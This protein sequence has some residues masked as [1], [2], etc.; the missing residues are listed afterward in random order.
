MY[1]LC[2]EIASNAHRGQKR[3]NGKPYFSYHVMPIARHFLS[4]EDMAGACV[5]LLHDTIEDHP[6]LVSVQTLQTAGVH[7]RIIQA[8]YAITKQPGESYENYLNR[9]MRNTLAWKVKIQD[10]LHNIS[11]GA[12]HRRI[13]KYAAGLLVLTEEHGWDSKTPE[14]AFPLPSDACF[15]DHPLRDHR[16][17]NAEGWAL[18]DVDST[19][20]FEIRRDGEAEVFETDTHAIAFVRGK[21]DSGSPYHR[22]ALDVHLMTEDAPEEVIR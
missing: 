17:C 9:V 20:I 19:G 16:I 3:D 1:A 13:R 12:D 10:M 14:Q 11:S 2:F 6:E 5:A 7:E 8:V 15:H 4:R 21:A 22:K 18:S